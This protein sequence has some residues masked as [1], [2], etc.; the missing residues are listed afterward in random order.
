MLRQSLFFFCLRSFVQHQAKESRLQSFGLKLGLWM[1]GMTRCKPL[2][3]GPLPI[4]ASGLVRLYL[5]VPAY[6]QVRNF[7]MCKSRMRCAIVR[8]HTQV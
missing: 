2:V 4:C 3:H 1:F 6:A 5:Y 7:D 8:I